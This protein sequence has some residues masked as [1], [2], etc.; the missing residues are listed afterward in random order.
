MAKIGERVSFIEDGK[1]EVG[2]LEDLQEL[3]EEAVI[4]TDDGITHIVGFDALDQPIER[5][6]ETELPSFE[7][8]GIRQGDA[9]GEP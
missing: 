8:T 9:T 7:S 3:S 6:P 4:T 1:R 5:L 2:A